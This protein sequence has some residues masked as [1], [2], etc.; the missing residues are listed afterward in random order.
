RC[1]LPSMLTVTFMTYSIRPSIQASRGV[2][3]GSRVYE[4]YNSKHVLVLTRLSQRASSLVTTT[5]SY[6]ESQ[7]RNLLS[8]CP[9]TSCAI[10]VWEKQHASAAASRKKWHPTVLLTWFLLS[11][12]RALLC[13]HL[14]IVRSELWVLPTAAMSKLLH[15]TRSRTIAP[16][17]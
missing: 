10:T 11:R 13:L 17:T 5:I 7:K 8:F 9:G 4:A 14:S 12:T 6:G 16:S 3:E 2:H 1:S 15:L